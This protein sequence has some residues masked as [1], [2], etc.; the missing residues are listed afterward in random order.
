[1]SELRAPSSNAIA[2]GML[3][4]AL[5]AAIFHAIPP[6]SHDVVLEIAAGLIGYIAK[7]GVNAVQSFLQKPHAP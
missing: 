2:V 1:M 5:V 7:A 4:V 6:A 3:G